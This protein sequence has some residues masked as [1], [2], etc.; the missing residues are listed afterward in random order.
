[1]S[2]ADKEVYSH[3]VG[4][5]PSQQDDRDMERLGKTQQFKRNFRFYSI[6]GFTTTLMASWESILLTSTYG[7]TDGGRAGMV[8]VYIASFVGFFASVISMAEIASIAPTSGGQYHW[9][10]EFAAPRFQRFL[11][12]ITGWLSVLGWQAAFA[13]I[14]F[15]CGTLIQGLLVFNYSDGPGYIYGFERWHGTLLTIAIAAVG[16]VVNTLGARLLPPLEGVILFLHLGGFLAVLV[17]MWAM[18]PG[19]APDFAVWKEFTNS[20]GWSGMGLACLVGQLTPLFSW[21]GPDAATHMAEE[22]QNA[23]FVVPWCMVSTALINGGLGFIMLITLVY[24]MGD[25]ET[26]LADPSGFS[27]LPAVKHA[28]GSTAAANGVAAI[29]LVM[30]VCSA[31]SIL[32][33]ASRQTFAFARDNALPFSGALANVNKKLQIPITSVIVS[34]MIT[35]LLCLINI[36]STAAFNAVASVMIAAL[37]TTYILSIGA[38]I[39]ARLLPSGVPRARFSLGKLGLPVNI[40]S[41]LYLCFAITFTFFPTAAN[42]TLV[43]MNWSILVFGVV[44]IFACVQYFI[45]GRRIYQA[46]V[47]QVRK[48]D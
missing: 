31:I 48:V 28:T 32:A 29:I 13:S 9:V 7:L 16:T 38:F 25:I 5:D 26:A 33:T 43:D 8:Y 30:E 17:P 44:V 45:H 27:F 14:C 39:R 20:G 11:S 23:A 34:T 1:M 4:L 46:P 3:E 35:V 10:S 21:T 24:N 18:G 22:I 12:Y 37:F 2:S 41:V 42:P 40:F 19:K 15:L 36:G 47:T 6:L